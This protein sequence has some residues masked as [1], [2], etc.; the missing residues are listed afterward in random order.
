MSR[1]LTADQLY[2]IAD[3]YRLFSD[4]FNLSLGVCSDLLLIAVL[5]QSKIFQGNQGAFYLIGESVANLGLLLT[6]LPSDILAYVLHEDPLLTSVIWCKIN[7]TLANI[8]GQCSLYLISFATFDQFLCTNPRYA[9]RRWST[10]K[11]AHHLTIGIVVFACLHSVLALIF[12]EIR[13]T[14]GCTIYHPIITRYYSFFYYPI[15]NTTLPVLVT[16]SCS[17]LAFRNVRR[18]VRR[19]VPIFRRRLDRQMTAMILAR[20]VCLILLGSA[21]RIYSLFQLNVDLDGR[22]QVGVA[23]KTLFA[24]ICYS[25]MYASFSVNLHYPLISSSSIERMSS[26]SRS[27]VVFFSSSPLGFVDK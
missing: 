10:L 1:S 16:V 23:I 22:D 12:V 14:M 4:I 9:V 7:A 15:L 5:S 6:K 13:S 27:I 3:K 25:L 8:F 20:V 2:L 19:Q 18:I 26:S 11:L 21:Y 24:A 17:L